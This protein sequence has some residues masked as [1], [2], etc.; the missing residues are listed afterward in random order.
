MKCIKVLVATAEKQVYRGNASMVVAPSV[1]GEI[2]M[3]PGHAP[4]LAV[5]KPGEVRID[6]PST[7]GCNECH[8]DHMLVFGGF[9]EVQPDS[10]TILADSI[11]RAED[12][13][14]AQA[15]QALQQA[16]R[17]LN[18]SNKENAIQAFFDLELAVARLRI[19]RKKL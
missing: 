6:C 19:A 15:Q 18:S 9:I 17:L 16:K 11:E 12:I 1:N 13:D 14:V 4:L 2:A 10:I 8:T 3:M 5:L 7:S